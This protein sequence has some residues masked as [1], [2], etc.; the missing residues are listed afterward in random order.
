MEPT[1]SGLIDTNGVELWAETYGAPGDPAV[2]LISGADSPGSRWDL[3][4]VDALVRAHFRVVRFDNRDCGL[5]TKVD[6]DELYTLDDMARD[7]VGLM[8]ALGIDRAHVV[9]R[10]MGG[11]IGQLLALD[12][13]ERVR[14]LA[15]LISS[16][17][18]GDERLPRPAEAFLDQLAARHLAPPPKTRE[19]RV[20]H[21]VELFRLYAGTAIPFEEARLRAASAAEVDRMWYPES[22][23]GH[24]AWSTT[25]RVDRLGEITVPTLIMHGTLDPVVPVAHAHLMAATIPDNECWI[26]DGLGHETPAAL[27]PELAHRL[28]TL[29]SRAA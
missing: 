12:H 9:G 26:I 4:L 13:R 20:D 23:H 21:L 16:P 10:S 24:A 25:S 11:M 5:S 27:T 17:G 7:V 29:F 28:L 22:G 19:E 2:V 18:M 6:P 3:D 14:S 1:T 8:D 15:L